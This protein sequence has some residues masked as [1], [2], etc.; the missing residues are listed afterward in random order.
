MADTRELILSRLVEVLQTVAGVLTVHRNK[1]S[2]SDDRLPAILVFDADE[3]ADEQD[4]KSRPSI[5]PRRVSMMPEVR[6]MIGAAP[7]AV[8]PA[9]NAIRA[10]TL[11]AILTDDALLA[12]TADGI[13]ARYEGCATQLK[14]GRTMQGDMLLGVRFAYYLKPGQL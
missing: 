9:L 10:A 4:P 2:L 1:E 7:E 13:G 14:V 8:G 6:I 3:A 12:L 5:A 11:K